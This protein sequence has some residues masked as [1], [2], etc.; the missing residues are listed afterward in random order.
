ME[1][2]NN[3][4]LYGGEDPVVET[5][6]DQLGQSVGVCGEDALEAPGPAQA[7]VLLLHE[8]CHLEEDRHEHTRT[9]RGCLGPNRYKHKQTNAC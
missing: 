8:D 9:T 3:N 5:A 7:E 6:A 4:D 1:E 2:R